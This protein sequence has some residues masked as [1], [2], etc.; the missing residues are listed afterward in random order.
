MI[1]LAFLKPVWAFLKPVWAFL[2]PVWAFLKAIPWQVW[3]V[4]AIVA[5]VWWYGGSRYQAGVDDAT[6]EMKRI[7]DKASEKARQDARKAEARHAEQV[8]QITDTLINERIKGYEKRDR[9]IADLNAGTVRLRK[10]WQGCPAAGVSE[11]GAGSGSA[12]AE[13][14]LRA[15]DAA[16]IIRLG[17]EAD[18]WITA[19][20]AVIASDRAMVEN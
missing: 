18:E 7:Y 19:C 15:A 12:D 14:Q 6:T 3:A 1:A 4:A 10:H 16:E 5:A 13:A 11:T 2:K 17:R 20:Q 9:L 8:Q